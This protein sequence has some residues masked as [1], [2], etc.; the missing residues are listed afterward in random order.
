[1]KILQNLADFVQ[2]ETQETLD[3]YRGFLSLEEFIQKLRSGQNTQEHS[4]EQR[5]L[6]FCDQHE[7][8]HALYA[9]NCKQTQHPYPPLELLPKASGAV[10]L[11][12]KGAFP[13]GA[14]PYP[15]DHAE[16]A[17][18]CFLL[19]EE[20]LACK[21]A[22]WQKNTLD[23]EGKPIFSLFSQEGSVSYTE[24]EKA[25]HALFASLD[26][27]PTLYEDVVD[28][29]VGMWGKRTDK[30]TL[31]SLATGCKSGMGVYLYGDAGILNYG[32]QL[33]PIGDCSGFG[34]AG[35]PENLQITQ[36]TFTYQTRIAAPHDRNTGL[37]YLKDSGYSGY[38]LHT[39]Q[40]RENS[41]LIS[42]CQVLGSPDMSKVTFSFF[43]KGKACSVSQTHKLHPRSLDRY[44]GPPQPLAFEG[45]H[46]TVQ[47]D[48]SKGAS[49]MVIIPLAGDD[50]FW[51]ADFLVAFTLNQPSTQFAF[52]A[53]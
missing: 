13:W 7:L 48:F 38:W 37:S 14:L 40:R 3:E 29:D 26:L 5:S 15:R 46:G 25:N 32:P 17:H 28:L 11:F 27:D 52:S 2:S 49:Q 6:V 18:L 35:K 9:L 44:E 31:L 16:L 10:P 30:M 20:E 8:A 24:L 45:D 21:M 34:L 51:G 19:G 1:M 22:R 41:S 43:G 50:S 47:L 12:R 23:H 53:N 4:S 33:L 36:E 39:S 42:H